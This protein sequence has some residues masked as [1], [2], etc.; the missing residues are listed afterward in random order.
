MPNFLFHN[1]GDG[2]FEEVALQA[3]TS[4][5]DDGKL[6]SSM[7]TEFKDY[8]N[9]GLPDIFVTALAGETFPVFRNRG[10]GNF[11]DATYASRM[12]PLSVKHSGWGL[13]L[14]DFNNDGWKDLFTA[15]SHVNDR[16]EA[17]EAAVYREANAVFANQDGTFRDVSAEAGMS[18]VKAHRGAAFADFD[19]DGRIDA[20]VSALG[21]PAELW[22][23]VSPEAGHWI[24][25][26]LQGVKDNR[27]GIG[28]RIRIGN[29]VN[30][31]TTTVG[32]ASSADW[33]V[34][35]GLGNLTT[36][37]KIEIRWPDGEIQT[38]T[39]VAADQVLTVKQPYGR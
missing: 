27:D 3:G 39:A 20:V 24:V 11:V 13:G 26:R 38:L 35:F 32:Y 31:M 19:G 36:I 12:G 17:F 23:N 6:I 9:D 10:K 7:G 22:Q 1:K 29:Q 30:E 15:N 4:L 25:L 34:H 21:E 37:P 5:R 8:D 2:T 14:F 33:G 16:V 28:A 18:L